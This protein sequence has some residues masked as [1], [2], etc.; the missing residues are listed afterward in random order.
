MRDTLVYMLA[1]WKQIESKDKRDP[2][3]PIHDHKPALATG[4]WVLFHP[5]YT[6][7]ENQSVQVCAPILFFHVNRSMRYYAQVLHRNPKTIS[8]KAAVTFSKILRYSNL[9]YLR[10]TAGLMHHI[11]GGLT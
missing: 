11:D 7:E 2:P 10:C 9:K 8:D 5:V 4:D 1:E 6:S 3:T